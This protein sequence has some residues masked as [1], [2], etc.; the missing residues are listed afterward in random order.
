[1]VTKKQIRERLQTD[2]VWVT[3]SRTAL[4]ATVAER[5]IRYVVALLINGDQQQKRSV[6]IEKLEEDGSYTVKF[7]DIHVAPADNV[8]IP[9][10]AY[11]IEDIILSCEGGTRLYGTVSGNSVN[12]TVVYWDNDV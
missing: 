1:M 11:D 2:S 3:T 8:Q 7:S 9:E 12:L 10:G 6:K 5:Y 4:F